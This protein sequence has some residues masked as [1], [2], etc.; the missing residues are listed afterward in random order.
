MENTD[1][2]YY[3]EVPRKKVQIIDKLVELSKNSG[4]IIESDKDWEIVAKLFEFF[5]TEFPEDYAYYLQSIAMLRSQ[6]NYGKAFVKQ[7]D[8]MIQHQ[9]EIPEKFAEMIYAIFPDQKFDRDFVRGLSK[10]LPILMV[11]SSI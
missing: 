6:H 8:A 5:K 9:L 1:Q 10:T 3:V 4:T 11:A 2:F 7:G